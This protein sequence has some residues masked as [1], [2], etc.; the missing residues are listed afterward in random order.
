M[1]FCNF[2]VADAEL[3]GYTIAVSCGRCGRIAHYL[4]GVLRRGGVSPNRQITEL[5]W[6]CRR[7]EATA[8]FRISIFLE[9]HLGNKALHVEHVILEG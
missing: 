3:G 4:P 8:G 6:R 7:C 2:T 9:R 1:E 5:R